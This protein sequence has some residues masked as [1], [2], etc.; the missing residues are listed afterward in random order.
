MK[1]DYWL[2]TPRETCELMR[3][4]RPTLYRLFGNGRLR[5]HKIGNKTLVKRE[6]V[7]ALIDGP[8]PAKAQNEGV[9]G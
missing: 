6:D 1:A 4:S 9:F 5:R 8:A 7:I 2:L 3:I